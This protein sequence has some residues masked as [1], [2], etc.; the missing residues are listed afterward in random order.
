[1]LVTNSLDKAKNMIGKSYAS[2][3]GVGGAVT[4]EAD[5]GNTALLAFSPICSPVRSGLSS[6]RLPR[7]FAHQ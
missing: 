7:L 3:L 4:E 1:M 6:H 2:G 5:G